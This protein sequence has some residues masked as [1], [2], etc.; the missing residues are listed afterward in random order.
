[1]TVI[2]EDWNEA[3]FK[4]ALA[5]EKPILLSIS[6]TWCHWCH[7]MDEQTYS[8]P[9][10]T[11]FIKENFIAI[12]IDTDQ[13]PDINVR[14]NQGGWPSTVFLTPSGQ[15]LTGA[16]FLPPTDFIEVAQ[17]VLRIYRDLIIKGKITRILEKDEDRPFTPEKINYEAKKALFNSDRISY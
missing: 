4:K 3:V 13:R 2:F 1:M 5:L 15:I 10:V 16:T 6:A 11:S 8:H 17:Q 9:K 12:R 14:Y 7:E